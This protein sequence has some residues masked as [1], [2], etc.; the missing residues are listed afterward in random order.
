MKLSKL[1]LEIADLFLRTDKF[2]EDWVS[3]PYLRR[4]W[5]WIV[6][7]LLCNLVFQL[8]IVQTLTFVHLV[9][10]EM[11]YVI[12]L[13][14]ICVT[15]TVIILWML[16]SLQYFKYILSCDVP[17]RFRTVIGNYAMSVFM[18]SLLYLSLYVL[19]PGSYRWD[20][21]PFTF[22]ETI[23]NLSSNTGVLAVRGQ[24]LLFSLC[25]SL[26]IGHYKIGVQSPVVTIVKA[27]QFVFTLSLLTLVISSYVSQRTKK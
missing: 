26:N 12:R 27:V 21:P 2:S 17:I 18:F 25:G 9:S 3:V 24:F 8:G 14:N 10:P 4:T 22:P 19:W 16:F 23:V 6:G 5:Y 20:D 1:V 15:A 11:T 13:I 7:L